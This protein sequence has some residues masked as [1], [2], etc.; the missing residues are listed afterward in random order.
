MSSDVSLDAGETWPPAKSTQRQYRISWI[1]VV[2]SIVQIY[3]VLCQCVFLM[4]VALWMVVKEVSRRFSVKWKCW[5]CDFK[6]KRPI[7]LPH[8]LGALHVPMVPK[9]AS[10]PHE[11]ESSREE[12]EPSSE[13][14]SDVP[15]TT[16]SNGEDKDSTAPTVSVS[17]SGGCGSS[18]PRESH[19]ED[20]T[21]SESSSVSLH[22]QPENKQAGKR[23]ACS[24]S[25]V[26]L[27]KYACKADRSTSSSTESIEE[28]DDSSDED[29]VTGFDER[30]KSNE[31]ERPKSANVS[32]TGSWK[33]KSAFQ[34]AG[35]KSSDAQSCFPINKASSGQA[36]CSE[37]HKFSLGPVISNLRRACTRTFSAINKEITECMS[38]QGHKTRSKKG[39]TPTRAVSRVA[40]AREVHIQP[41]PEVSREAFQDLSVPEQRTSV[42]SS[43]NDVCSSDRAS[44][45][46]LGEMHRGLLDSFSEGES[47]DCSNRQTADRSFG[48]SAAVDEKPAAFNVD[49]VRADESLEKGDTDWTTQNSKS[50]AFFKDEDTEG[51]VFGSVFERN[52]NS[53]AWDFYA[54]K[55]PC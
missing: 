49:V 23:A 14:E 31:E 35:G 52:A 24:I 34:R 50:N 19:V 22:N 9:A 36:R 17:T 30:A 2:S 11:S 47:S 27:D 12:E 13:A 54:R 42:Q 40:T 10:E 43:W 55:D 8:F 21:E 38:P 25:A 45:E 48:D 5:Y 20:V 51:K 18:S 6:E 16:Q 1:H 26:V 7:A 37:R 15:E 3:C 39:D 53:P 28:L 29:G 44:S 46:S 32:C 33:L 4:V 41:L